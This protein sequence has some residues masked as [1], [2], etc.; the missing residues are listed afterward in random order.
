MS[1]GGV[2]RNIAENLARLGVDVDLVTGLGG[3]HNAEQLA[4]GCRD[5]G[6]GLDAAYVADEL[7]GS[8]YLAILDEGGD[9]ALALNDMRALERLTPSVLAERAG[10]FAHADLVVIDA[11]PQPESLEWIASE[12]AAP[13]LL[14]PVSAAKAPRAK[15]ILGSLAALKCNALEAAALLGS[16]VPTSHLRIENA[17]ERLLALGVGTVYVTAG[18]DGVHYA[19]GTDSGWVGAPKVGVANAT[20]AGDAFS[21]GVALG[22][23]EGLSARRCAL[24]GTALAGFTLSSEHTVNRSITRE[25]VEATAEETQS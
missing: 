15:S 13:L 24:L 10:I 22:M 17:A 14:D 9:M 4:S 11:N 5:A 8:L 7:P 23:L 18:P 21:A 20:G 19:D 16:E 6:V 12:I 1:S 3:D 2:G 25:E